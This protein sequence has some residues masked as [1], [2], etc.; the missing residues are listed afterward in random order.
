MPVGERV[1][2]TERIQ[3]LLDP[4][5]TRGLAERDA[6]ALR[7]MRAECAEVETALSYFR[8]L[9][10]GRMEILAAEHDRRARGGSVEELIARLPE[11]LGSEQ[12]RGSSASSRIASDQIA[13]I[14]LG[15]RAALVADDTLANLP[16]LS[17]DELGAAASE[18]A[19]FERDL[20]SDRQQLHEVIEQIDRQIAARAA[21]DVS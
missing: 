2:T 1:R 13:E 21:A 12:N 10:Q 15:P 5:F 19:A 9:A 18:L 20:S 3:R 14:D 6:D 17:D 16:V 7:S 11:I 8:R 4:E